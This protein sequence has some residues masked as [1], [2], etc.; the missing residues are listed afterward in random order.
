MEL[1][2]YKPPETDVRDQKIVSISCFGLDWCGKVD[3]RCPCHSSS[4]AVYSCLT[5]SFL[6]GTPAA[7]CTSASLIVADNLAAK[8]GFGMVKQRV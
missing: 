4:L 2:A 3:A 5:V 7:L 6:Y 1:Q 8:I